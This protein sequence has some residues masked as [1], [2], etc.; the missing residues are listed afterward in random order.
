MIGVSVSGTGYWGTNLVR[1]FHVARGARLF[2][3]CDTDPTRLARV[4]AQFPGTRSYA[5]P[6]AV[7]VAPEICEIGGFGVLFAGVL[8]GLYS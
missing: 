3:V 1:N 2:G 6:A 4:A 8:A 5:G 7:F